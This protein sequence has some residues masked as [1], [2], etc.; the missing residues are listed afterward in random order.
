MLK[1][2]PPDILQDLVK[3]KLEE[4]AMILNQQEKKTT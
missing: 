3:R 4:I 2:L 1:S